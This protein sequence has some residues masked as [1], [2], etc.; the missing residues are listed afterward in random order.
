MDYTT[1][2]E[3]ILKQDSFLLAAHPRPDGDALGALVSLGNVLRQQG[4]DVKAVVED[5]PEYRFQFIDSLKGLTLWNGNP[6]DC[7]DKDERFLIVVDTDISNLGNLQKPLL[8][9]RGNRFMIIDH[10]EHPEE[11]QDGHVIDSSMSSTCEMLYNLFEAMGHS[12]DLPTAEALYAGIVFDTGS[13]VYPKTGRDSFLVAYNLVSLGVEPNKIYTHLYESNTTAFLK[14]Q[15]RVLST[16]QL[17][18]DER[19]SL[20]EMDQQAL[21][22][23]GSRYGDSGPLINIPLQCEA[24]RVSLFLKSDDKGNKRCSLRSKGKVNVASLAEEF[25]GGGHKTAAGFSY[26]GDKKELLDKLLPLI[27]KE[28]D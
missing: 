19:V 16:L 27:R 17:Y 25:Q 22:D 2:A 3:T 14:L 28:L 10:H 8:E 13:F 11:F 12:L 24:I 26:T 20:I 15:S 1:A 4:K 9:K 7:P 21:K 6:E 5:E 23:T 18:F